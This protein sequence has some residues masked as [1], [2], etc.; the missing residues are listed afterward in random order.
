MKFIKLS[1]LVLPFM[2]MA[3]NLVAPVDVDSAEQN[4]SNQSAQVEERSVG[5]SSFETS[6]S[7]DDSQG[8][9]DVIVTA[10]RKETN[11]LKTPIA[12]TALSQEKLTEY[13]INNIKDL[14][15]QIPGLFIQNTDTNAPIITLRGVRS[16]NVTEVGDPAVGVHIDGLYS[17]RPQAAQALMFDLERAEL[18]RGPQGT[19]FGR[20]SIAG[21]LNI[22]TAKPNLE[23]QGGSVIVS[24]GEL[25][26]QG[27]QGHYNLP[28]SEKFAL[29][30]AASTVTKDSHIEGYYDPN[31]ADW[32]GLPQNI[33]DQITPLATC[34]DRVGIP[35]H[36]W[37][38]GCNNPNVADG[39]APGGDAGY[40]LGPGY[41]LIKADPSDF[42]NNV[43]NYAWRV[44]A[45]YVI[46][47]TSDLNV[48][49]EVFQDQSAGYAPT[50][51]CDVIDKRSG[52]FMN[53]DGIKPAN[54]CQDIWGTNNP[55]VIFTNVA[56]KSDIRIE[57][58]RAI[59]KKSFEN[60]YDL[61]VKI[62]SQSLEQYSIQDLD[63]GTGDWDQ[64]M[65]LND[66]KAD[67]TVVD[68]ELSHST[69]TY[70]W[71]VGAFY[72]EEENDMEAYY[73]A[74]FNGDAVFLQP[75][76]TVTSEAVFGQITYNLSE[77]LFLTLGARYTED[78]KEDVGG[79][80]WDCTV[81]NQ[82]Y[83]NTEL[84]YPGGGEYAGAH[85]AWAAQNPVGRFGF[86]PNLASLTHDFH[87]AGGQFAGVNC[88]AGGNPYDI[89]PWYWTIQ[90]GTGCMTPGADNSVYEKYSNTDWRIGL[91][92]DIDEDNFVYTY[93]ATG[94]KAGSIADQYE[95]GANT[96]NP[97]GPGSKVST[98]YGPEDALTFELGYKGKAMDG[99]L[100]F[101]I[102]YFKTIYDGKQFTGNIPVD[103]VM[104]KEFDID[105]GTQVD[106]EQ[107]AY[108]WGTQ[109]FGE[110]EMAGI[111]FD[112]SLKTSENGSLSGWLTS[113]NTEI[114]EDYNTQW[115]YAM[116][117]QFGRDY[118]QA[119]CDC[120]ENYVNLKGNEAPYSPDIALTLRYQHVFN[121][122]TAGT[123]TPA[124]NYH[125][126]SE[127]YMTPWNANN[128]VNDVGGFGSGSSL[129]GNYT[130][131]P[132]YFADPVDIFTD[133]R[134]SWEMVDLTITY[135]P[136]GDAPWYAQLSGYNV[137]DEYVPFW[138]G[139]NAGTPHGGYSAP[140]HYVFR[141]GYY[142]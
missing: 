124:I 113:Y 39:N 136:A 41:N 102:N 95:R 48:Q 46:D 22:I 93:L 8:I 138:R 127:S 79:R 106:V 107:V 109:N 94:Y 61:K 123:V 17:A 26:E 100:T 27:I 92:Y 131:L 128:H 9:E 29:R 133:E 23:I 64:S 118:A 83:T 59:Y 65:T 57:S 114:T 81:W 11:I 77:D 12:V 68:I 7:Y 47:D 20:N 84:W 56:G 25:N 70:A 53:G 4:S 80:N 5:T 15:N 97:A 130:D 62:G 54:S 30:F 111:E 134:P 36:A 99:N 119:T 58:I 24:A 45:L 91:D 74:T 120:V 49:Y 96:T 50:P 66:F 101:A 73:H 125:Y 116:D 141:V 115:Y 108:V 37:Y 67:S 132:G 52:K 78:S 38:W 76:R 60:G 103:T 10:T 32:R 140:S 43:D 6:S 135:K 82:C 31:Q 40:H 1:L 3:D 14:S 71:V 51:A 18:L 122:G 42:Y 2:V 35:A 110:Q 85:I 137:T 89:W 28:V 63:V 44:S 86:V 90:G 88:E 104:V 105:L 21:T 55:Y 126:E 19:L 117:A 98:S 121:L 13:G 87:I 129:N 142:W 34:G 72:L 139:V 33:R 112:F 16:N 69:D 75:D